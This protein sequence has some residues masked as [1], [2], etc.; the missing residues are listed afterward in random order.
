MTTALSR[1]L[2]SSL[3]ERPIF[4]VGAGRSGTTLLRS[5]LSAHS[6][7]SIAPETH[8]MK[9]ADVDSGLDSGAPRDFEAFWRSYSSS[10][11]FIDLGVDAEHCRELIEQQGEPTFRGIFSAMLVAYGETC[12]NKARIGE[13]TP[14]NIHFLSHLL[15]WFPEA[16]VIILRRDPRAMVASQLHTPWIRNRL[17]PLS[18]RGGLLAGKRL[19]AVAS[20]ANGWARIYEKMVPRWQ[21]DPRV[22]TVSYEA[23]VQDGE[24]EIRAI[25]DFLEEPYEPL[26]LSGRTKETVPSPTAMAE[27]HDDP[28]REWRREHHAQSLRPI[29]ADSIGKWKKELT[30]LEV[31]MI[32]GRCIRGMR[33]AGYAPSTPALQRWLGEAFSRTVHISGNFET[34]ARARAKRITHP[35][36]S[37]AGSGRRSG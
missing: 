12:S 17:T 33:A 32:E 11:R 19:H 29:S 5:L 15:E 2:D 1:P 26:M 10:I 8:F 18:L 31:G 13:K 20:Q 25:C 4:I 21:G 36:R 16:Q 24:G 7:I 6:R 28:W 9:T 27:T 30:K 37:L 3:I 22:L 34:R 14:G 35:L 23:L